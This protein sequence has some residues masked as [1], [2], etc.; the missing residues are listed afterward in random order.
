MK[1]VKF[2]STSLVFLLVLF[3]VAACESK[4]PVTEEKEVV[5]PEAVKEAVKADA[6]TKADA[7]KEEKSKEK[8]KGKE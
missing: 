1:N 8:E 7:K 5:K 3:L 2:L 4:S 6:G